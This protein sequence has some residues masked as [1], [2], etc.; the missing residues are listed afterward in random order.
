M[1]M[2]SYMLNKIILD[3]EGMKPINYQKFLKIKGHFKTTL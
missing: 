2:A 1:V 3:I